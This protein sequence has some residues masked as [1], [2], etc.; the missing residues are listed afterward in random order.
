[1]S[2]PHRLIKALNANGVGL[3]VDDTIPRDRIADLHAHFEFELI[4]INQGKAKIIVGDYEGILNEGDVVLIGPRLVHKLNC[5]DGASM[6]SMYFDKNAILD[7]VHAIAD[8]SKL[9]LLLEKAS[10]GIQFFPS[11]PTV[12]QLIAS[13]RNSNGIDRVIG[14]F[15]LFKNLLLDKGH[16]V[17]STAFK[18]EVNR[19]SYIDNRLNDVNKYIKQHLDRKITLDQLAEQANM[20]SPAFCNFFKKKTGKTV[21]QQLNEIRIAHAKKMILETDLTVAEVADA[22][23]YPSTSFFNRQFKKLTGKSPTSFKKSFLD[24]TV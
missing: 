17:L 19:E 13:L 5:M 22:C 2:S 4:Y 10:F 16:K 14:L 6:T 1:M 12:G 8:L 18:T 3:L 9:D 7:L 20:S 24:L 23:G 11:D 15:Q 21:F